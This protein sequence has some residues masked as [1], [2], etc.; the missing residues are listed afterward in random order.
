MNA[1]KVADSFLPETYNKVP[2]NSNY[3]RLKDGQNTFRVLSSAIVGWEY[4]NTENKPVLSKERPTEIPA[5]IKTEKDGSYSLKHFWAFIV[6]N[7]EEQRV[8]ILEIT[9]SSIQNAIKNSLVDNARWGD[10][11]KYDI[12]ITRSGTGFD[13][14]Y[15]TQGNPPIGE[16]DAKIA[17]Q[18]H[19]MQIDLEALYEGKDPFAPT[20][21]K[22]KP[23]P[24][25]EEISAEDIPL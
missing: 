24:S 1:Q 5:D 16:P 12:T 21:N 15:I 4:W 14:E 23:A 2:S 3:M 20:K 18:R 7:Y 19:A 8:Q 25:A 9:Q 22:L 6:W 17:A 10:P 11:K 13:T